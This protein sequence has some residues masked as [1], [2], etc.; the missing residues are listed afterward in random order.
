LPNPHY[1]PEIQVK[2]TIVNFTVTQSG[3]EDQLLAQVVAL[4]RPDLEEQKGA[5]TQQIND[6]QNEL[7]EL[8]GKILQLLANAGDDMLDD[9]TLI[10]TLD[11]SKS[12]SN[13]IASQLEEAEA[14]GRLI[15]ETRELYRPAATRGSVLYFAIADMGKIDDMYQYSL[16]YFSKLFAFNIENSEPNQDVAI[17]VETI[18]DVST[19]E[20]FYNICRGLFEQD[21]ILLASMITF[22]VL[23]NAGKIANNEWRFFLTGSGILDY[24]VLPEKKCGPWLKMATWADLA[25]LPD[26]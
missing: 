9:E 18:I 10:T 20:I 6:G 17:R 24:S 19:R 16:Q 13:E 25:T 5:L 12:T 7:Y 26:R 23:R 21:K 4:E 2:V 8:E 22:S 14:T 1:P 15:D 11:D 3:L